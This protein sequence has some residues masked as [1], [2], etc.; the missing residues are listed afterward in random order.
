MAQPALR[1]SHKLGGLQRLKE[2][3][4]HRKGEFLAAASVNAVPQDILDIPKRTVGQFTA[5]R[6]PSDVDTIKL[7]KL[8]QY[9]KDNFIPAAP[10]PKALGIDHSYKTDKVIDDYLTN[11]FH[12]HLKSGTS[13]CIENEK[14]EIA[15][16]HTLV[17]WARDP[18]YEHVE[19]PSILDW[20]NVA[21][22][23]VSESDDPYPE[24]IWRDY[25]YMA[26]YNFIQGKLREHDRP[27]ILW[28]A[29]IFQSPEARGDLRL[30]LLLLNPMNDLATKNGGLVGGMTGHQYATNRALQFFS[31]SYMA[32][33]LPYADQKLSLGGKRAFAINDKIGE[34]A[35][36]IGGAI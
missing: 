16:A 9:L 7:G 26:Q 22:E 27:F 30:L 19:G 11:E 36:T 5:T 32:E 3:M 10:I 8:T 20:H 6:I 15:G 31:N 2:I 24:L 29:H 12:L 14:K 1:V 25:Q 21:A 13:F 35:F 17:C 4:L 34:A 33:A 23:I 28:N 18:A